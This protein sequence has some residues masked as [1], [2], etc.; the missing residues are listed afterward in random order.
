VRLRFLVGVSAIAIAAICASSFA[1][2]SARPSPGSQA[3]ATN[4]PS[5]VAAAD[6]SALLG[7]AMAAASSSA[8]PSASAS[9]SASAAST[10]PAVATTVTPTTPS[11]PTST[12]TPATVNSAPAVAAPGTLV[13][14]GEPLPV[15]TYGT[16]TTPLIKQTDWALTLVDTE[17]ELPSGWLP[18]DLVQARASG[19]PSGEQVR[20]VMIPDLRRMATAS[21]AAGVLLGIVSAYRDYHSQ[22][23]TFLHWVSVKGVAKALVSSALAGHSEHQL[24]LAIDFKTRGGPD[25]WLVKNWARVSSAGVWL[26][27]N[28]WKYGFVMSYPRGKTALTCYQYEPWHFRYVGVAE[29]AAIRASGLTLRQW[30][31]MHQP[32]P[33]PPSP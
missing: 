7:E 10:Q 27:A 17:L 8:G 2:W 24:G 1:G 21:S 25:P 5:D 33:E 9:A 32:N 20:S 3:S 4:A 30:L 6:Q 12:S 31:W 11:T 29:A 16:V 14:N 13:T 26:A 18:D 28:A 19:I 22:K 23:F 15:C